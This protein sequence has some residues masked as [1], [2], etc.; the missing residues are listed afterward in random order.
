MAIL[1]GQE[2]VKE[3]YST[4]LANPDAYRTTTEVKSKNSRI[5]SVTEENWVFLDQIR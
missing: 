1:G 4:L 5:R 2:R 3:R